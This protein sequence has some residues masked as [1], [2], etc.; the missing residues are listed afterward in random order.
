VVLVQAIPFVDVADPRLLACYS[1]SSHAAM[2]MGVDFSTE[3]RR[4][5]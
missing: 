3:N 4:V 5:N 2:G 1:R